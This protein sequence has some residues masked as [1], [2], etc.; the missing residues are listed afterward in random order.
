MSFINTQVCTLKGCCHVDPPSN[1][2][3]AWS[4]AASWWKCAKDDIKRDCLCG[5]F[6]LPCQLGVLAGNKAGPNCPQ[7]RKGYCYC[8][9]FALCA[10]VIP[11]AA[12][13]IESIPVDK[14]NNGDHAKSC[15]PCSCISGDGY[16]S[17]CLWA[18]LPLC[19][20][21]HC[22]IAEQARIKEEVKTSTHYA[23]F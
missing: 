10:G 22:I 6:C 9:S 20:C 15:E 21:A 5:T 3:S 13:C 12:L 1:Q 7:D 2:S 23:N 8:F 11:L 19:T 17:A 14:V 4:E 16:C 18:S